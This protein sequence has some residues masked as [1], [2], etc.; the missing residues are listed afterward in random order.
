MIVSKQKLISSN[1][2][3]DG[4]LFRRKEVT[5]KTFPA[6]PRKNLYS[7]GN[8]RFSYLLEKEHDRLKNIAF[9]GDIC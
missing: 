4:I 7:P 5:Q 9:L 1:G 3:T 2:A 6:E 8:C